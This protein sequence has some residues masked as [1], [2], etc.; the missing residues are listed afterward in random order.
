MPT[1]AQSPNSTFQCTPQKEPT[2]YPSQCRILQIFSYLANDDID[3]FSAQVAPD[4]NWTV[5]GTHPLAGQYNNRTLFIADT[6]QRLSHTE[7]PS[8][9][10]A[11]TVTNIIGGG[12]EQWSV[13]ELHVL[14]ACKNGLIF[15][16]RYA[17]ATRWNTKGVIVE[18]R[19]YLDSVLVAKAITEN[20]SIEHTYLDQRTT[21]MNGPVGIGC[22]T[23]G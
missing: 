22:A 11:L 19:A 9:P 8:N 12:N 6:L 4:V 13:Q 17:W 16:N 1:L 2:T 14:G 23:S 21:L 18:A 5:M 3:A 15:D 7:D 20:E 10:L